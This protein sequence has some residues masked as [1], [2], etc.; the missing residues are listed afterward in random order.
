MRGQKASS[1]LCFFNRL[2]SAVDILS[3]CVDRPAY[4]DEFDP[5]QVCVAEEIVCGQVH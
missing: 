4:H 2:N 3:M 1:D 5:R